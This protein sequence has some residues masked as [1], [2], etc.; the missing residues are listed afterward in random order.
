MELIS[1]TGMKAQSCL[2]PEHTW[3]SY[4]FNLTNIYLAPIFI[5]SGRKGIPEMK[6]LVNKFKRLLASGLGAQQSVPKLWD[7]VDLALY[8]C[9]VPP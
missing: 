3:N 6:G 7:I 1:G 8:W 4:Q 9:P 2:A 5:G